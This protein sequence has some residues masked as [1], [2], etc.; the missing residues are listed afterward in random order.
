MSGFGIIPGNAPSRS[1]QIPKVELR[2]GV[3]LFRR[4]PG[5]LHFPFQRDTLLCLPVFA[6]RTSSRF[7]PFPLG[8]LNGRLPHLFRTNLSFTLTP[9]GSLLFNF[10]MSRSLLSTSLCLLLF[11]FRKHSRTASLALLFRPHQL[12]FLL[13]FLALFVE[14]V[15]QSH[16]EETSVSPL[17]RHAFAAG[18][19]EGQCCHQ[20]R[21]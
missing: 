11:A 12:S 2:V 15:Y 3:S 8:P 16:H 21:A 5:V 10:H 17:H 20:K 19:H 6:F 13:C 14:L 7:V 4:H 1:V 18:K 9:L